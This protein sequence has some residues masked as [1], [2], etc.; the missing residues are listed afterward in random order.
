VIINLIA[1]FLVNGLKVLKRRK[2]LIFFLDSY[3]NIVFAE[4]QHQKYTRKNE[5]NI[6]SEAQKLKLDV[7]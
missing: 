7:L 3:L 2:I 6:R 4:I 5:R 1:I